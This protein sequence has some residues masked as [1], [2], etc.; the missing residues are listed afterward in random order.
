MQR[1]KKAMRR[2]EHSPHQTPHLTT[3]WSWISLLY[4]RIPFL[5]L[6]MCN[7]ISLSTAAWKLSRVPWGKMSRVKF[8]TSF[9][10]NCEMPAIQIVLLCYS[11]NVTRNTQ[12][13]ERKD[14]KSPRAPHPKNPLSAIFRQNLVMS[15]KPLCFYLRKVAPLFRGLPQELFFKHHCGG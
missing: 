3:S 9:S 13:G 7:T 2:G 14:S 10:D 5:L 8:L 6:D 4:N 1:Q 11:P 12:R 15:L